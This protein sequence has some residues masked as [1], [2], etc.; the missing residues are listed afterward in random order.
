MLYN[1]NLIIFSSEQMFNC[2]KINYTTRNI[3]IQSVCINT[4]VFTC[5]L[6]IDIS[7]KQ[8]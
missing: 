8:I 4:I 1:I 5:V 2:I 6:I 7:L 3:D